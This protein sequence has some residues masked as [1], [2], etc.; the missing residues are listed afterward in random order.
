MTLFLKKLFFSYPNLQPRFTL[1]PLECRLPHKIYVLT[2]CLVRT[3]LSEAGV[4]EI[5]IDLSAFVSGHSGA[6]R[7]FRFY[8]AKI[9]NFIGKSKFFV[10]YC[11]VKDDES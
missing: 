4:Q 11:G 1:S 2:V 8:S 3:E 10:L 7:T 5:H 9:M 6:D